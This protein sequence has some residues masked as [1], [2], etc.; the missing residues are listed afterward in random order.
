MLPISSS[1]DPYSYAHAQGHKHF[2][3]FQQL[4]LELKQAL[5]WL[6]SSHC[7]PLKQTKFYLAQLLYSF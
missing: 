4:S 3:S 2:D 6:R 1:C 7:T 5:Q